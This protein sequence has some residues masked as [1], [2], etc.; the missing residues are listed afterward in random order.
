MG[1]LITALASY[2]DIKQAGG[3][4]LVR[5]DDLDPPRQDPNAVASIIRS[6]GAHG[7]QPDRPID[8]Q[9][10]HAKHYEAA[11]ENSNHICS[12][13]AAVVANYG[14]S[15]AIL[16]PADTKQPS[17]KTVQYVSRWVTANKILTMAFWARRTDLATQLGTLL[18]AGKMGLLP[19]T[20]PLL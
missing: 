6:L 9:S 16:A 12:I 7:L 19:T 1:S 4:W 13:A 20:W 8:F 15:A 2:C 14:T 18:C 11:L 5:I 10:A 3:Q 17:L